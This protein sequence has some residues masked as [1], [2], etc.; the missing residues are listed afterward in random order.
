[1]IAFFPS[2]IHFF[3]NCCPPPSR[4]PLYRSIIHRRAASVKQQT[5][6]RETKQKQHRTGLY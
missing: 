1:M 2:A 3:G 5:R 6:P 4:P